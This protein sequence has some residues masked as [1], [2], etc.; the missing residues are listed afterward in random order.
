MAGTDLVGIAVREGF[1]GFISHQK[2]NDIRLLGRLR[3]KLLKLK[4]APLPAHHPGAGA[5]LKR[6]DQGGPLF[7]QEMD[8]FFLLAVDVSTVIKTTTGSRTATA[9]INTQGGTAVQNFLFF[10]LKNITDS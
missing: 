3:K 10:D 4:S 7:Q 5:G 8:A 9:P 1:S 6:S 2:V